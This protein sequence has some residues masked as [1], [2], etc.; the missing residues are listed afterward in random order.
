MLP[1]FVYRKE[2]AGF[3]VECGPAIYVSSE[4]NREE[5]IQVAMQSVADAFAAHIRK[6]P[7]YWYQFYRFWAIQE[8]VAA[9]EA[10]APVPARS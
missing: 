10:S 1:T 7:E 8:T 9:G 2:G 3:L 5:N 4:G 6:R